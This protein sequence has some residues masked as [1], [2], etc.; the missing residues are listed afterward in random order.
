MEISFI[1]SHADRIEHDFNMAF[2]KYLKIEKKAMSSPT[3]DRTLMLKCEHPV[4]TCT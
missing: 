3:S 2:K 4:T 1:L